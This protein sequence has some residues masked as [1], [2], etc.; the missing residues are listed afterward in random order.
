MAHDPAVTRHPPDRLETDR[1]AVDELGAPGA[2][3]ERIDISHEVQRVAVGIG[4]TGRRVELSLAGSNQVEQG[5]D[6][7]LTG[8][9]AQGFS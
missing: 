2:T 8:P 6:P 4:R 3:C 1:R 7:T 5:V 9:C